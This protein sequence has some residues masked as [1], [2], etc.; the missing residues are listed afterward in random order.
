MAYFFVSDLTQWL[1]HLISK[2]VFMGSNMTICFFFLILQHNQLI[3]RE[4]ENENLLGNHCS[5][6]HSL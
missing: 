2:L 4:K 1:E 5:K 6:P 3:L